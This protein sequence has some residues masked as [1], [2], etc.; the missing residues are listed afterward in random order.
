ML[1]LAAQWTHTVYIL[2]HLTNTCHDWPPSS[3]MSALSDWQPPAIELSTFSVSKNHNLDTSPLCN[4]GT[5]SATE[6]AYSPFVAV[7]DYLP[8]ANENAER[9]L[10]QKTKT[11]KSFPLNLSWFVCVCDLMQHSLRH[12]VTRPFHVTTAARFPLP[13]SCWVTFQ[14]LF[15]IWEILGPNHEWMV[16]W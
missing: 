14:A 7:P 16:I 8:S 2:T 15:K 11:K 4:A 1:V 12:K 10:I 3:E 5:H 9:T 13:T 6:A